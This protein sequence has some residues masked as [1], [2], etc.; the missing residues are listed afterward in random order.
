MHATVTA[1]A[2][3]AARAARFRVTGAVLSRGSLTAPLSP[4]TLGR[5]TLNG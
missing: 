1:A 3:G 4:M 5:D 2:A